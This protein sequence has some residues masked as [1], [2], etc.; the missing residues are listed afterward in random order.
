MGAPSDIAVAIG[1]ETNDHPGVVDLLQVPALNAKRIA[2]G[3]AASATRGGS[4]AAGQFITHSL[5][6]TWRHRLADPVDLRCRF[7]LCQPSAR[8][9][10]SHPRLG[11]LS[12]DG[13]VLLVD[14]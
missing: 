13:D 9:V 10:R 3:R 5:D 12:D 11:M 8:Q 1:A 14:I 2:R 6:L 4:L 7:S